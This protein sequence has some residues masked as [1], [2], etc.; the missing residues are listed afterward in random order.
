MRP[1]IDFIDV[2]LVAYLIY[3]LLLWSKGTRAAEL[4]KGLLFVLTIYLLSKILGFNTIH[5]LLE[6]LAA[7]LIF[8]VIVVFQPELRKM[9]ERLGRGNFLKRYVFTHRHEAGL[10]QNIIEAVEQLSVK[11]MGS[12]IVFEREIHCDEYIDTGILI[13]SKVSSELLLSIFIKSSP[14][15]DGAA[16]IRGSRLIA[17]SCLLPLSSNRF[18]DIQLGTRHRAAIGLTEHYDSL[19]I[20]TSEETGIISVA[21]NGVI[22]RQLDRETLEK[23]LLSLYHNEPKKSE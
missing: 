5:W 23:R 22:S 14:L 21:E 20:I 10:I 7:I 4:T 3:R 8:V 17:A 6:K 1:I 13:D 15:H 12:I 9:L 11:K 2:T 18:I 16:I 19:A